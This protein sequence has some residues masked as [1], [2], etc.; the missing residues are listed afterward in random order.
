MTENG[1]E[2]IVFPSASSG[3]LIK[4]RHTDCIIFNPFNYGENLSLAT[5]EHICDALNQAYKDSYSEI[6]DRCTKAYNQGYKDGFNDGII[7]AD[8]HEEDI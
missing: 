5:M 6:E 8:I 1:I 4:I 3:Y 7:D 2:Y